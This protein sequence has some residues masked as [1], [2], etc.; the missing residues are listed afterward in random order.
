MNL[1]LG[2]NS[3]SQFRNAVESVVLSL[4]LK[5]I[6]R[7]QLCLFRK[8]SSKIPLHVLSSLRILLI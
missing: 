1:R 5:E 7:K 2:A 8:C 4:T 3:E 6:L